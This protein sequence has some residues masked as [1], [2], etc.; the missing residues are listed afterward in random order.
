MGKAMNN[1]K[2]SKVVES[3]DS[4]AFN[5]MRY[6]RLL[7]SLFKWEN[8]PCGIP[9]RFIEESLYY[10]G[11]VVFFKAKKGVCLGNYVVS[12]ATPI[13]YNLYGDP[14]AYNCVSDNGKINEIVE[15]EDCVA[16]WNN[17]EKL[18]SYQSVR[19][20]AKRIKD[21]DKTI[22]CNMVSI[23][24]PVLVACSKEQELTMKQ[25][26]A[27][28]DNDEPLI[29]VDETFNDSNIKAFDM[30]V[31]SHLTELY[32]IR[33]KVLN[34]G[35]TYFGINNVPVEKKERLITDE[36]QQNNEQININKN[37]LYMPR[38]EATTEINKKF[39][40]DIKLSI[41]NDLDV[42]LKLFQE[43]GDA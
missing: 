12:K 1:Y 24:H 14:I 18:P 23:K 26:Y 25:F 10:N 19:Y 38:L 37:V 42:V 30:K 34:E 22:S 7:L 41:A 21:L 36:A 3:V 40:L 2:K 29:L 43:G 32:E 13:D 17:Y 35:L 5:C 11:L 20:F 15:A 8:L 31:Q 27:K 4:F 39:G 28:V 16:I 33:N 6:K 9:S